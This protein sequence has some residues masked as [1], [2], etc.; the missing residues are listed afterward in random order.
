MKAWKITWGEH[1]WTEEDTSSGHL[2]AVADLLE[3]GAGFDVSPWDG[4]K[5]LAA[6]ITVMLATDRARVTTRPVAQVVAECMAEVYM[7]S[8]S[9]LLDALGPRL[10]S[11]AP[12]G[13]AV[14]VAA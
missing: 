4:P 13:D 12:D 5:Q 7:S 1:S 14:D 11:V 6:W 2:I 9:R 8:P 3:T 10:L